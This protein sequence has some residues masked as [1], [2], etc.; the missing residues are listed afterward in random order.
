M[1][2]SPE[3]RPGD[4]HDA[5]VDL[6]AA[7]HAV[8][9]DRARRFLARHAEEV[10]AADPVT[11]H[12]REC[13]CPPGCDCCP[14]IAAEASP[15]EQFARVEPADEHGALTR[16]RALAAEWEHM[17]GRRNARDELLTALKSPQEKT[18]A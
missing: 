15:G 14:S 1:A 10:R 18:D 6:L 17:S 11:C 5:L 4:W 2:P 12:A 8:P 3:P 16:V 7:G 9:E 13:P